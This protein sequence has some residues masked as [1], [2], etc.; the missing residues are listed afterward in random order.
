MPHRSDSSAAVLDM[1]QQALQRVS[2]SQAVLEGKVACRAA[3]RLAHY[4]DSMYCQVQ[5]QRSSPEWATAQ[6]VIQQKMQQVCLSPCSFMCAYLAP[7]SRFPPASMGT[8]KAI[9]RRAS[10]L[11]N[12]CLDVDGGVASAI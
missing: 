9:K 6:A 1:M 7:H 2:T 4:A 8:S 5:Q 10:H 12:L 11:S 3:Y